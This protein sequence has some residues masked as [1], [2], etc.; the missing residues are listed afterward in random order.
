MIGNSPEISN[1]NRLFLKLNR[2]IPDVGL[3]TLQHC[4]AYAETKIL[5]NKKQNKILGWPKIG[6]WHQKL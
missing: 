1:F 5:K 4:K 2:F 6:M 3:S